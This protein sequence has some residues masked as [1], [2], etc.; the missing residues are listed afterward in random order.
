[1]SDP[2]TIENAQ[3]ELERS[4]PTGHLA[5]LGAALVELDGELDWPYFLEKPWKWAREYVVWTEWG[6]PGSDDGAAWE[7]FA[8]AV[9]EARR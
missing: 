2:T 7:G 8:R 3:R 6:R 9:E 4:R 1:M 5:G